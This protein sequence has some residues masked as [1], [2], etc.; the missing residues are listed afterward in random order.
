M[1]ENISAKQLER[2]AQ[3]KEKIEALESELQQLLGETSTGP[4]KPSA[5]GGRGT[6]SAAGKARIVAT[7]KARW[8]KFRK[9]KALNSTAPAAT[10][11][12]RTVSAAGKARIAA[13]ARKRWKKAKAAGKNTL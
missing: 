7:Q 10:K 9:E 11:P 3:L 5:S 2:A 12:K 6:I 13:A 1:F 8:A 4:S